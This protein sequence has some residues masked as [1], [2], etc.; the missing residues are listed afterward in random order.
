MK[1]KLRS[2]PLI[3]GRDIDGQGHHQL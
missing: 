3:N 1:G 2:R